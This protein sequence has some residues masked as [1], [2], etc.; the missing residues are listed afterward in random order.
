VTNVTSKN[1]ASKKVTNVIDTH[2]Y[3]KSSSGLYY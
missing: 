1:S 3:I 2:I